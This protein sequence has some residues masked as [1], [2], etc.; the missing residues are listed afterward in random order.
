MMGML[1][2]FVDLYMCLLQAVQA[3][4]SFGQKKDFMIASVTLP[5]AR[6]DVLMRYQTTVDRRLS[7]LMAEY[8]IIQDR[9]KLVG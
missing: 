2:T 4:K 8:L 7:A 6:S 9:D 3:G 1:N 5:E